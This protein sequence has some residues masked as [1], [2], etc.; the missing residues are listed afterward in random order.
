MARGR[1]HAYCSLRRGV[2]RQLDTAMDGLM[3]GSSRAIRI[4]ADIRGELVYG[5]TPASSS[6]VRFEETEDDRSGFLDNV[7][8]GRRDQLVAVERRVD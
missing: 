2:S 5:S 4:E 1:A 6:T 8:R 3:A 7:A